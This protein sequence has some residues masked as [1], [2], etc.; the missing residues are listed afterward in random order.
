MILVG[1]TSVE[2]ELCLP[3]CARRTEFLVQG[4]HVG[5]EIVIGGTSIDVVNLP[6]WGVSVPV[7]ELH[8]SAALQVALTALGQGAEHISATIP[9]GQSIGPI[10]GAATLPVHITLLG[11]TPATHRFEFNVHVTGVCGTPFVCPPIATAAKPRAARGKKGARKK[12][13][14]K[15]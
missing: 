2:V 7:Y 15:A 14:R 8:P 12:A 6:R 13:A 10:S 5:P 11:G 1:Q 3:D 4:V 9:A